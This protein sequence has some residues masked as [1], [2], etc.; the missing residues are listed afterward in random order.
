[1]TET[2]PPSSLPLRPVRHFTLQV[3]S[4]QT[5][6]LNAATDSNCKAADGIAAVL[7]LLASIFHLR[8][9]LVIDDRLRDESL[10]EFLEV[11]PAIRTVSLYL[12]SPSCL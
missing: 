2:P 10:A 3:T 7:R 12:L 8:P 9:E 6:T 4:I 1:V 5:R 11:C